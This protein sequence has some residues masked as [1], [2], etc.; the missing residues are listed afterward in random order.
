MK[1]T[2]PVGRNIRRLAFLC[3][4]VVGL[5]T[6]A[7]V[8]AQTRQVKNQTNQ[9]PFKVEVTG[10]GRPMILIPGLSSSGE[11]WESTVA[12]YKANYECHVLTLA[13]F[14]GEPPITAPFLEKER[15]GIADYIRRKKLHKPVMVGHSL[16]G[17]LTLWLASTDPDLVGPIIIV[18]M[19]PFLPAAQQPN[20]TAESMKPQAETMRKAMLATQTPEQRHQTLVAIF[21]T[22]ITDPVNVALAEKWG[23]ASDQNTVAQAMYELFTIDI[24][25]DL[26][27]IKAPALVIGTWVG[28]RQY[29]TKEQVEQTFRTQ[30]ANLAGYKLVMSDKA[31]HFVM[32]D[33]PEFLFQ[34]MDSFLAAQKKKS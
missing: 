31:K 28:L 24:R 22:M 15:L 26:S 21:Q 9:Y 2:I 11:V 33:D 7:A 10:R 6:S 8:G 13:G 5:V 18:D 1:R 20:A 25:P 23:I 30:F 16:G 32:L 19:L 34:E 12:R 17:F 3:A 29:A 27:R 4:I 14:A